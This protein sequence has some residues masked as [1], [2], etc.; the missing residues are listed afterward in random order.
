MEVLKSAGRGNQVPEEEIKGNHKKSIS[1]TTTVHDDDD[2][3][4][5]HVVKTT[6]DTTGEQVRSKAYRREASRQKKSCHSRSDNNLRQQ[7]VFV[8]VPLPPPRY[9]NVRDTILLATPT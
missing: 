8:N 9:S 2:Q 5:G 7:M 3:K 1:Y 4:I 6:Y